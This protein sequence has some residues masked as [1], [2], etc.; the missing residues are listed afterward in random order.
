M[1]KLILFSSLLLVAQISRAQNQSISSSLSVQANKYITSLN[2]FNYL[3]KHSA[4][5][6]NGGL[7]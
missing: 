6:F 2:Y 7:T 5:G 1:K 3:S 4:L